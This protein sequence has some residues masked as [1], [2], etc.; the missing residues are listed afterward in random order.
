[1]YTILTALYILYRMA[2]KVCELTVAYIRTKFVAIHMAS[3][4]NHVTT[5]NTEQCVTGM[6]ANI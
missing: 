3:R 5:R 6:V 4:G 1:M 2:D